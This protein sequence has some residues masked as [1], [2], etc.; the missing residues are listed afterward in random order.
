MT[1][2]FSVIFGAFALGQASPSMQKLAE[3]QGAA[4]KLFET[5]DRKPVIDAL[6]RNGKKLDNVKGNIELKNIK[7][8]YPTR[9]DVEVLKG[10]N[11]SIKE[12]QV[13][14]LII[15]R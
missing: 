3:A 9:P 8:K 15:T 11:L 10:L 1:V 13:I 5:I 4:Y 6:S 14:I 12:G 7:F 2:L